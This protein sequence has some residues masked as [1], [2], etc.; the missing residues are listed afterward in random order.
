[1]QVI[2][3]RIWNRNLDLF[4]V[5]GI[6]TKQLDTLQ[7]AVGS[8]GGRYWIALDATDSKVALQGPRRVPSGT[9]T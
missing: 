7:K 1:M 2:N 5:L 9:V 8:G 6:Q 3:A 4:G